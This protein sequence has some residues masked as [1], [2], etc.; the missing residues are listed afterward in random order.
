MRLR[1]WLR[2]W[3][4]LPLADRYLVTHEVT[5]QSRPVAAGPFDA[6][7]LQTPEAL[8]PALCRSGEH[9][10]HSEGSTGD[11]LDVQDHDVG[12]VNQ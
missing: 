7:Q 4:R 12:Q 9:N 11:V 5:G 1:I 2:A 8:E 10:V 3:V 6:D